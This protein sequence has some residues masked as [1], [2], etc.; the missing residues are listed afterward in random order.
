MRKFTLQAMLLLTITWTNAQDR[1]PPC[2]QTIDRTVTE[3][4]QLISN[5]PGEANDTAAIRALFLPTARFTV[6]TQDMTV[7]NPLQTADLDE[8][9]RYMQDP[10]YDEGFEEREISRVVD[11]YRNIAQVFQS[12]AAT[13]GDTPPARG[14]TSYQL[15]R[16]DDRWRIASLVWTMESADAP[17]PDKYLEYAAR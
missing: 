13:E 1:Q 4:L 6:H 12:F 11:E 14:I 17:I 2:C 8:F 15:V 5:E 9:L 3:L 10:S 7:D 16:V